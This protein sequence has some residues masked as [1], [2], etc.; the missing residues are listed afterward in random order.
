MASPFGL[1]Q[2]V[3]CALLLTCSELFVPNQDLDTTHSNGLLGWE[4]PRVALTKSIRQEELAL[5]KRRKQ[6]VCSLSALI[7]TSLLLSALWTQIRAQILWVQS[8]LGDQHPPLLWPCYAHMRNQTWTLHRQNRTPKA[9][10]L[11]TEYGAEHREEGK[12]GEEE[13]GLHSRENIPAQQL[14]EGR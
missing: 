8:W 9:I 11:S 1:N 2:A 6:L 14:M 7:L 12:D 10:G 13:G 5:R 4:L 3:P